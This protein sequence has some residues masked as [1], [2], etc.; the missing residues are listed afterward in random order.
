MLT[1]IKEVKYIKSAILDSDNVSLEVGTH[2]FDAVIVWQ[3]L[4]NIR[5]MGMVWWKSLILAN[6][7]NV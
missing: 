1:C 4:W 7:Y 3:M 6:V 5:H 2:D